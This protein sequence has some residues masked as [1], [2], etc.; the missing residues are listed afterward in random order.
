VYYNTIYTILPHQFCISSS[1]RPHLL[2][3]ISSSSSPPPSHLLPL[4]ISFPFSSP[5]PRLYPIPTHPSYFLILLA[6]TESQ[7]YNLHSTPPHPLSPLHPPPILSSPLP[8]SYLSIA[9]FIFLFLLFLLLYIHFHIA[10]L[11]VSSSSSITHF[12]PVFRPIA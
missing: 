8:F 2:L 6:L 9:A 10:L 1:S 5:P 7:Q 4:L 11:F 12:L 3:L